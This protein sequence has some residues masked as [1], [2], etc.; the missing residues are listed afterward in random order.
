[1]RQPCSWRNADPWH[2]L[3]KALFIFFMSPPIYLLAGVGMKSL[4]CYHSLCNP[5]QWTSSSLYC[6]SSTYSKGATKR[7]HFYLQKVKIRSFNSCGKHFLCMHWSEYTTRQILRVGFGLVLIFFKKTLLLSYKHNIVNYWLTKGVLRVTQ[8][9]INP[10]NK[11]NFI[12]FPTW[13]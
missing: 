7:S 13:T 12:T 8:I 9:H 5:Q 1:M 2:L 4:F 10:D 3:Q 6:K 11:C